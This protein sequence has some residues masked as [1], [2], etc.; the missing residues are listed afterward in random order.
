MLD[1]GPLQVTKDT[2][3]SSPMRVIIQLFASDPINVPG[4]KEWKKD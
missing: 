3:L 2:V 1:I 4:K